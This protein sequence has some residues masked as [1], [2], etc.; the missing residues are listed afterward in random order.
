VGE[1]SLFQIF[2]IQI[3]RGLSLIGKNARATPKAPTR[4]PRRAFMNGIGKMIETMYPRG[5]NNTR[6]K[7]CLSVI[8]PMSLNSNEVI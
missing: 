6:Y 2:R 8:N 1:V 5:I 7:N 3:S 4:I